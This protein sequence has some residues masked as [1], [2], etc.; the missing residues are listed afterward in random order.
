[1]C[2]CRKWKLFQSFTPSEWPPFPLP[3]IHSLAS[4]LRKHSLV[5]I[6][7]FTYRASTYIWSTVSF[8]IYCQTVS[9][10]SSVCYTVS[11]FLGNGVCTAVK[12]LRTI[13]SGADNTLPDQQFIAVCACYETCPALKLLISSPLYVSMR[14][15]FSN[16]FTYDFPCSTILYILYSMQYHN[17]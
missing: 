7:C 9:V 6:H 11:S 4:S 13:T 8:Y 15:R 14:N 10:Y 5:L 3:A 2:V 1:M 12:K 17:K 16:S